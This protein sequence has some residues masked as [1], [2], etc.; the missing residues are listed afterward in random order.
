VS[1]VHYWMRGNWGEPLRLQKQWFSI[2]SPGYTNSMT[3]L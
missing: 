1:M 3:C 2:I